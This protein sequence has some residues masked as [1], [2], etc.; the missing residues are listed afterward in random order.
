M[1]G[2][3]PALAVALRNLLDNA[4]KYS[5]GTAAVE[6]SCEAGDGA[7]RV[8]VRDLG[9]GLSP[10][11]LPV[12]F[13]RFTRGSAAERTGAPGTGRSNEVLDGP[14]AG[15]AAVFSVAG[16]QASSKPVSAASAPSARGRAM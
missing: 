11:D 13:R 2:D 15:D 3:E 8:R 9:L 12:V 4:V 16:E 10:E 1:L 5:P 14:G 7:L 6:V